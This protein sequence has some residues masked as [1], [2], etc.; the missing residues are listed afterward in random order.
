MKYYYFIVIIGIIG[1][2]CCSGPPM[3]EPTE[4]ELNS[5]GKSIEQILEELKSPLVGDRRNA[6]LECLEYSY[7]ECVPLLRKLIKDPDPGVRSVSAIALGEFQDKSSLVSIISLKKDP[8]I[9]PETILDALGR[10]QAP[11]AGSAMVEYLENPNHTIRLLAVEALKN[12]KAYSVAP[13]ILSMAQKNKD[14]E[15]AKTYAMALGHLKYKPAEDYL[16]QLVQSSEDG[17]TKAAAILALGRVGSRKATPILTQALVGNF[18]KGRENA[19]QSLLIT[20]D[21]SSFSDLVKALSHPDK[22]VR[23]FAASA[24]GPLDSPAH[25]EVLR[26]QFQEAINSKE[27]SIVL[28]P[29]AMVLGEWKDELSRPLIEQALLDPSNPDREELARSLGWMGNPASEEVLLKV[30]NETSGEGRY[31]AAWALGFVG[32]ER[33]VKALLQKS[34]SSDRKLAM[35]SIEA[36][37]H[38]KSPLSVS[39]LVKA[40]KDDNLAPFAIPSLSSI[41]GEE[42]RKELESLAK[43]KKPIQSKLAIEALGQRGDKQSEPILIELTQSKDAEIRKIA[44]LALKQLQSKSN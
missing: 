9:F 10:M 23:F 32:G 26:K 14:P 31:G 20:K 12:C 43:S 41:P 6:V 36:L 13:Q 42:A 37:G 4:L 29:S 19:Y 44:R 21:P 1:V 35:L 3:P 39:E 38:L 34:R 28:A 7:K 5:P 17:P 25:R 2:A 22:E 30:L 40:A 24:L 8:E 33:S 18:P 16:I 11:E 27:K 15:K